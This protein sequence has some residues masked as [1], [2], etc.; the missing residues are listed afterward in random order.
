MARLGRSGQKTRKRSPKR[1]ILGVFIF[2][3]AAL[4]LAQS[5]PQIRSFFDPV[6]TT[7][8]DQLGGSDGFDVWAW[9]TGQ[10]ARERRIRELEAEVRDLSR[11]KAAAISMAERMEAYEEILNLMGEPPA[12]GVTARVSAEN[13]GPFA[14]TILANAGR[15][16]GVEPGA[17]ALN[18][19]GLV[20]RVIQL[21]EHSSRIL[22]IT[23]F[24][25]RV[26]V[27]GEVS[28]VRAI[29]YGGRD[30]LGSLTDMPERDAFIEGER[31]L[32]SAE[33]GA[34]P[35]GLIVGEVRDVGGD[36]RVKFSMA[37][38]EGGYVQ[39]VPPPVIAEPETVEAQPISASPAQGVRQ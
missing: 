17:V 13:N 18:E 28:G 20:G 15:A 24:N 11:Y 19:G 22:L 7:V 16:Q 10:T 30:G 3:A 14:Q 8:G 37:D 4:V 9:A 26:P 2:A 35:R 39:M 6:R 27:M 38:R 12:R 23:D 33:G 34:F 21:G 36:W 1:L 31:I 32:T 25:S 5:A 29:L